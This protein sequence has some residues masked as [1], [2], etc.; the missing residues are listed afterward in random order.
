LNEDQT[1]NRL[2]NGR[3]NLAVLG[4]MALN[5]LNAQKSKISTRRKIKRAGWSD[6]FLAYLLAQI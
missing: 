1:R 2:D 4:H 5:I 3:N 6:A